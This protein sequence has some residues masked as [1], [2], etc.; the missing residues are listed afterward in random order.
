MSH[1][2]H[3]KSLQ[4]LN[5]ATY[6]VLVEDSGVNS[7]YLTVT[8][9]PPVFSIG[10]ITHSHRNHRFTGQSGVSNP[11]TNVCRSTISLD[12]GGSV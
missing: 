1:A 10:R 8:R 12:I 9:V 3:R 2:S 5:L 11:G 6:D 7:K 4:P